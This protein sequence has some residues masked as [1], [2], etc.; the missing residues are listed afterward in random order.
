MPSTTR[1]LKMLLPITLLA[2]RESLFLKT[3]FKLTNNSGEL[4]P[5][6]TTVNPITI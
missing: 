4:V 2:A 3:E 5:K 1:M 6:E